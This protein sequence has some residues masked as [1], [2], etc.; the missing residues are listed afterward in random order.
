MLVLVTEVE[1]ELDKLAVLVLVLEVWIEK[2]AD[3]EVGDVIGMEITAGPVLSG[4]TPSHP[5]KT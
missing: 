4:V 2:V 5:V 1:V 3:T